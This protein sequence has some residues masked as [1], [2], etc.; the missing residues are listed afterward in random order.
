MEMLELGRPALNEL[1]MFQRILPKMILLSIWLLLQTTF[2]IQVLKEASLDGLKMSITAVL[3][4]Q[5]ATVPELSME[6]IHSKSPRQILVPELR[7]MMITALP[8]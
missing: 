7:F 8:W 4:P 3:V 2:P 6:P 1:S 5:F